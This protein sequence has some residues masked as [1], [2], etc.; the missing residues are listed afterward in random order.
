ML[1]C[2]HC[3]R[4]L[5]A[6]PEEMPPI[7]PFCGRD[8]STVDESSQWVPIARVT[9]LAEVGFFV[10][11]LEGES[12]ESR[13]DELEDFDAVS[14]L[15]EKA[16]VIRVPQDHGQRAV[17]IFRSELSE[18]SE[19]ED[20]FGEAP[21]ATDDEGRSVWIPLVLI[22]VAGGLVYLAARG[23]SPMPA[24]KRADRRQ[25]T[26]WQALSESEEVFQ[27]ERR[28]GKEHRSLRY[29]K[30]RRVLRLDEDLDGD[31]RVDRRREFKQG[32]LVEDRRN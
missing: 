22:L 14:G 2:V 11:R 12:I 31:G 23:R 26:L 16:F 15:W 18:T 32:V 10:E 24:E 1:R 28:P 30:R 27:T 21:A 17:S 4:L 25:P 29:D 7:C 6:S 13:V 9:S 19:S 20:D 5:E 8:P 3:R